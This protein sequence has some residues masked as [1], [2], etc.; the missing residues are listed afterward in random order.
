MV[1]TC[2]FPL[3]S[4][5]DS[6]AT[7]EVH[8]GSDVAAAAPSV[9]TAPTGCTGVAQLEHELGTRPPWDLVFPSIFTAKPV[10]LSIQETE[11]ISLFK[12]KKNRAPK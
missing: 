7:S 6:Q 9:P 2:R 8:A 4:T 5:E 12:K 3:G 11:T 1:P 10:M